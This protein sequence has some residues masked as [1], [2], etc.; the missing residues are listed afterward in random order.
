M[1]EGTVVL[2]LRDSVLTLYD[3]AKANSYEVQFE[4]GS[5]SL[6]VPGRTLDLYTD[7]GTI[8]NPPQVRYN[9]DQPYNFSFTGHFRDTGLL[10]GDVSLALFILGNG[11]NAWT[12]RLGA[13][14]TERLWLLEWDLDLLNN[15]GAADRNVAMDFCGLSGAIA[16][17]SPSSI[18]ANGTAFQL[19]PTIT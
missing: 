3:L 8:T 17:G 14:R 15:G 9:Q 5:L 1:A 19:Y 10:A 4:D 7:R 16:E 18:T 11:P 13:S 2:N 6:T 12:S